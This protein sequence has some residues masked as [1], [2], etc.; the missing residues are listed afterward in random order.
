MRILQEFRIR[1]V[2]RIEIEN[3]RAKTF[4]EHVTIAA[5][6][7]ARDAPRAGQ[8]MLE[9]IE[10]SVSDAVATVKEGLAR[11]YMRKRSA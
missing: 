7:V 2:R 1:F 3:R 11:I 4:G 10:I 5:A 9:H 8:L 6:L